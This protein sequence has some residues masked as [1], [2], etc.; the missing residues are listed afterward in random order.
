MFLSLQS[1]LRVL[2]ITVSMH[3]LFWFRFL[4]SVVTLAPLLPLALPVVLPLSVQCQPPLRTV[5]PA[6]GFWLKGVF[7]EKGFVFAV[8]GASAPPPPTPGPSPPPPLSPGGQW[9]VFLKTPLRGV[10]QERGGAQGCARGIWGGG[11]AEA[12]FTAKTSPLFGQKRLLSLC[13]AWPLNELRSQT[14]R[15]IR[16]CSGRAWQGGGLT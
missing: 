13:P 8:N 3:S 11:G 6:N 9:G 4:L 5:H 16:G 15:V 10:F 14:G 1:S 2:T 12:P 7:A